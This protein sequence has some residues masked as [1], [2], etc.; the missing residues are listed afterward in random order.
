[1]IV[2][3]GTDIVEIRRIDRAVSRHGERFADRIA[4]PAELNGR[5]ERLA[6]VFAAK[7]ACAKALGTGF[8]QGVGFKDITVTRSEGR[9]EIMLAGAAAT[10]A[11]KLGV[12][13]IHLSLAHERDY[14]VATVI[15][16]A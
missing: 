10:Q 5:N 6:A 9:P 8:S 16:E 13:Q 7:E 14:A 11:A 15:L 4:T 1:M 2:G 12:N 3:L